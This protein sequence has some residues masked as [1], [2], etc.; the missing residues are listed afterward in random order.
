[1]TTQ[2]ILASGSSRRR[3]LLDQL[4]LKYEVIVTGID[5][6]TRTGEPAA[7]YVCRMAS[8]KARCGAD[9]RCA[10]LPVLAA[11]T[12]VVI[13]GDILG[14]PE[15][16]AHAAEM[17]YRLSGRTHDVLSAVVL[18]LPG[19]MEELRLNTSRVSFAPLEAGWI[20]SYCATREPFDKAGAYAIQGCAAQYISKLEGSYSGVMGLP[21]F[22]TA[23][24]LRRAGI[25]I[26]P[27]DIAG[28]PPAMVMR[29]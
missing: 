16:T 6:S 11:D 20:A 12:E 17:L 22:E 26:L 8:E 29:P 27:G 25:M 3:E 15:N 10:D 4:G 5:E 19:G 1:M 28:K 18:R 13:D 24:L 14:K 7:D 21:L 2:F 9:A 23:E